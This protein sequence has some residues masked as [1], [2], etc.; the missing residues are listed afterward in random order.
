MCYVSAYQLVLQQSSH[1]LINFESSSRL[2]ICEQSN[3]YGMLWNATQHIL[4]YFHITGY[5]V[6]YSGK[7]ISIHPS[8]N[9]SI[10]PTI[11]LSINPS[12]NPLIDWSIHWL[13]DP[14]IYPFNALLCPEICLPLH[15]F[16]LDLTF[17]S[18]FYPSFYIS[19]EIE[20]K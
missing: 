17:Q 4:N 8:I 5:T 6:I 19:I 7:Y 15:K 14:S 18:F 1:S 3:Y 11:D 13:I 12:I 9:P 2:Y 20:H 16:S 10:D